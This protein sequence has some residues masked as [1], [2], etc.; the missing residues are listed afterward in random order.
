MR[1][2]FEKLRNNL[3]LRVDGDVIVIVVSRV[4]AIAPE[5]DAAVVVVPEVA[6]AGHVDGAIDAYLK[7]GIRARAEPDRNRIGLVRIDRRDAG[8]QRIAVNVGGDDFDERE[9][10]RCAA[11]DECL[12]ND[13]IGRERRPVGD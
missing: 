13:A 6:A 5:P 11:D 1:L 12:L 7:R 2:T 9:T 4:G 8:R 3:A 10:R